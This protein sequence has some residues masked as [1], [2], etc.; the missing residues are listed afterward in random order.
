MLKHYVKG[1]T[2]LQYMTI[3]KINGHPPRKTPILSKNDKVYSKAAEITEKFAQTFYK[4]S[5][6][7]NYTQEFMN[8]KTVVEQEEIDFESNNSKT[9]NMPFT[10]KE[11]EQNLSRTKNT[12]PG[13][14][15][16]TIKYSRKRHPKSSYTYVK[17]L[18]NYGKHPIFRVSG[19]QQ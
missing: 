13:R 4:V 2:H 3:R 12:A 10:N 15:G 6:N 5:S 16:I 9:Y 7:E 8:H 19:P 18:T 1:H 17:Y 11:L 14:D